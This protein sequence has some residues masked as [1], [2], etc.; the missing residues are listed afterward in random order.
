MPQPVTYQVTAVAPDIQFSPSGQQI[1]GKALTI[2]T[3][4]GYRGTVFVPSTLLGD[5][6]RVKALIESEVSQ[7][8]AAQA[9]AGS[10]PG[11]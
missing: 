8:V 9:I 10:V 1:P 3:S 4:T 2:E 11:S 5:T 6:D 7:V